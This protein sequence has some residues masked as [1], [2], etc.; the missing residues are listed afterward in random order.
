MANIG[1]IQTAKGQQWT[2]E[3]VLSQSRAGLGFF[4]LSGCDVHQA[5]TP[6]MSVVVDAGY[7]QVGWSLARTTVAGG[8]VTIATADTTNPRIDVIYVDAN[9]TPGVYAGTPAAISPASKTDFREYA[10]PCP[11]ASIPSGVILALVQVEANETTI[12]N[13]DIL[14]IATYGPYVVE[15]PTSITVGNVPVWS[16]T[17]KTLSDGWTPGIAA[18][19]LLKLDASGKMAVTNIASGSAGQTIVQGSS[20][21]GWTTRQFNVAFAFGDGLSVLLASNCYYPIP[22]ASKIVEA[23]IRSVDSTGAPLSGSVTCT[24]YKHARG[25]ALGTLVDTFA[26]SSA[27]NMEETSLNIAVT[28]G[29]YLTIVTSGI[30]TCKQI[31]C[32]LTLEPTS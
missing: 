28:A 16:S 8:T 17:A 30:A 9:G 4:V 7:I 20:A 11:G 22:I 21:V 15:S 12:I 32:T 24:L 1:S 27:T 25:A 18:N 23:E 29:D 31:V 13:T 14:D 26:I 2:N 19:N 5:G 3:H 6:A 10:S